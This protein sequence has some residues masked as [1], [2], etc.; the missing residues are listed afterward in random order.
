MF[1]WMY[2][3]FKLYNQAQQGWSKVKLL[4]VIHFMSII[5]VFY[6]DMTSRSVEGYFILL[7]WA[8]Y[9]G[10]LTYSVVIDSMQDTETAKRIDGIH[11][12]NRL[13]RILM[14]SMMLLIVI[15]SLT[16]LNCS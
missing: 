3:G 5:Y 12:W 11:G 13:F 10:F 6:H 2:I 8:T 15:Y 4:L 1:Y 9:S 14:H 7:A 16:T